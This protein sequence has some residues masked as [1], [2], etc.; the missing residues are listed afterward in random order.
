MEEFGCQLK[1]SEVVEINLITLE[2]DFQINQSKVGF[3]VM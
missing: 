2:Y 1:L 3:K